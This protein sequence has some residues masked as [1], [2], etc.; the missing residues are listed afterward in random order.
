MTYP[1]LLAKQ[2]IPT[3]DFNLDEWHV[4]PKL[5]GV[6]AYW[7]GENLITRAGN[8][9]HAPEFFTQ[10][11]SKATHLDGELL[12]WDG[13]FSTTVSTVRKHKPIDLEW[14][15]IVY[16]VFDAPCL[17][18]A[19]KFRY[20]Y[21]KSSYRPTSGDAVDK[22]WIVQDLRETW[23]HELTYLQLLDKAIAYG[24]EGLMFRKW[25]SLYERKRSDTLLKLKRFHDAEGVVTGYVAGNGK[26]E[27]RMGALLVRTAYGA[28]IRLG[29]GF[30][31][32][33][34][35]SPP[36]IGSIVTYKYQEITKD[37]MPRFPVFVAVRDYE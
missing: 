36:K 30:S 2:F 34:R 1:L 27:G 18:G 4:S 10:R 9:I 35:T 21:L 3:D 12:S 24:Y 14:R 29:T 25:N 7:N 6:R 19:F 26:H 32:E 37:G 28:D 11:L 15:Q 33:Q 31:D 17:Q 5:D 16:V 22:L 8:I 13:H 23:G 20:E